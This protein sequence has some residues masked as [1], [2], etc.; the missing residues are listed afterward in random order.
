MSSRPTMTRPGYNQLNRD[1]NEPRNFLD[2]IKMNP[3]FRNAENK[4]KETLND[5]PAILTDLQLKNLDNHKYSCVG[6]TFLDPIFQPFWRWLVEQIPMNIA[7]NLLTIIG[8]IVNVITS[9]ILMLY[10]PNANEE[11]PRWAVFLC[12]LGLF[13]YQSLDAIDGKQARRTNSSTPL[14]ELFDHG[15]DAISTVFVAIAFTVG[16]QFG[17]DPWTMFSMVFLA[18]GAFYTAHWQTYVTGSLKF[19]TIDVTEAQCTIYLIYLFNSFFGN[20]IWFYKLPV[21][22]FELRY[23]PVV[24]ATFGSVS[25][26]FSNIN[27]ISK[28]G[29]GKNGSSVAD[30]SIVFPVFPLMLFIFLGFSIANKSETIYLDNICLYLL[31]FGIVW[32][33]ITI[34]LIIAHM[35][36]G[37][38]F[39]LDS[40]LIGPILLLLNQYFSYIIPELPV[41]YFC[42]VIATADLIKYCSKVCYQ[43]CTH[44]NIYLFKITPPSQPNITSKSH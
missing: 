25:S 4:V 13:I 2:N 26:I 16:L 40:C 15:C 11:L 29:K 41:L 31:A 42:L 38:I 27:T 44:M 1:R 19:G 39:L 22:N 30:S 3:K 34:K 35:T 23:M 33:K 12:A 37:E 21:L 5:M 9:T 6:N 7:P 14:G 28:G 20:S 17:E 43:I 8:L 18:M 32:S 36:K 24:V 10:S